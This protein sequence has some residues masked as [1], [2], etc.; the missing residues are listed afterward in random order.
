[1]Y[2][3]L[4]IKESGIIIELGFIPLKQKELKIVNFIKK[5]VPQSVKQAIKNILAT[6][7]THH[8]DTPEK[9]FQIEQT[10]YEEI[11]RLLG[12]SR[13]KLQGNEVSTKPTE[14]YST[15]PVFQDFLTRYKNLRD[16]DEQKLLKQLEIDHPVLVSISDKLLSHF[17]ICDQLKGP[18]S[19]V[20][21]RLAYFAIPF[22]NSANGSYI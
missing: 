5:L 16:N 15:M 18:M 6:S 2:L 21:R 9:S 4:E 7:K 19:S 3:G 12:Y 14:Q 17:K 1:M 11:D 10:V 8:E 20:L 22:M 13:L